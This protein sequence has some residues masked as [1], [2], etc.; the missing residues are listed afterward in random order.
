MQRD[1]QA[2]LATVGIAHG[3]PAVQDCQRIEHVLFLHTKEVQIVGVHRGAQA[4]GLLELR[5]AMSLVW[6]VLLLWL[7]VLALFV[8]A[9]WAT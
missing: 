6:R 5:D 2:P 1:R 4:P 7:G 8:L 9:G 3:L